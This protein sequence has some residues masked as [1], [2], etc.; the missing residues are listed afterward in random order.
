[1]NFIWRFIGTVGI[2][3]SIRKGAAFLWAQ[4][5]DDGAWHS[6]TYC[7]LR[8]GQALTPF[9]LNTLLLIL[10]ANGSDD[11]L[12]RTRALAFIHSQS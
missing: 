10:H 12:N 1:M 4:Q 11:A 3:G 6:K 8:S 5:S 7:L 9:A 2:Q